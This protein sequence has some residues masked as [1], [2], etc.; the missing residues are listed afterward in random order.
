[1]KN[2]SASVGKVSFGTPPPRSRA[3]WPAN[4]ARDTNRR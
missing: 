1:M 2:G 4:P 3:R